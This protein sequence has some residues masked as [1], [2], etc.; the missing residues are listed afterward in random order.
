MFLGRST[1][2][3]LAL[4]S[5]TAGAVQTLI[6]L[7][8]PGLDPVQ[9]GLAIGASVTILGAWLVFL[10]NTATTP[11]KDPQL[12][13]GTSVRVTDAGGTVIGNANVPSPTPGR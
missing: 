2:Q 7:F 5:T 8:V 9:V 11:V 12:V 13:E 4:I 10:A 1:P 6:L 3:W